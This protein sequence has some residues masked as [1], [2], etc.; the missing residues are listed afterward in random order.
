[1]FTA[2]LGYC[3]FS[4]FTVEPDEIGAL[5]QFMR[6]KSAKKLHSEKYREK[7]TGKAV[8]PSRKTKQGKGGALKSLSAV[9]LENMTPA[10]YSM[11]LAD[12]MS[13]VLDHK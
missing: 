2:T 1:M 6:D 10:Q 4:S 7:A 8:D 3:W 12:Q 9:E 11:M 5:L 13:G